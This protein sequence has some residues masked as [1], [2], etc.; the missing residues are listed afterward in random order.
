MSSAL[1][2]ESYRQLIYPVFLPIYLIYQ[3]PRAISF[4]FTAYTLSLADPVT[5]PE[6]HTPSSSCMHSTDCR[7]SRHPRCWRCGDLSHPLPSPPPSL[8]VTSQLCHSNA[9]RPN[10][11]RNPVPRCVALTNRRLRPLRHRGSLGVYFKLRMNPTDSGALQDQGRGPGSGLGSSLCLDTPAGL[12]GVEVSH[13]RQINANRCCTLSP[14]RP[15]MEEQVLG[16]VFRGDPDRHGERNSSTV[17]AGSSGR[18]AET[19]M[20]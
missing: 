13:G 10:G 15:A 18:N 5:I 6:K 20:F 7:D 11:I 17:S 2:L 19:E 14:N 9:S 8:G 16:Q 4:R 12:G 1:V 3:L